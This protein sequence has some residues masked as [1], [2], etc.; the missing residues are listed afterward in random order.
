[1][2]RIQP[3]QPG[4]HGIA[5]HEP[6]ILRGIQHPVLFSADLIG[7]VVGYHRAR[8]PITIIVIRIRITNTI[9]GTFAVI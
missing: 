9:T 1:M 4:P 3:D 5:F 7:V 2:I 8:F 6:G